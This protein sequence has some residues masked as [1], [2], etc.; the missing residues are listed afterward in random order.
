[1][2]ACRVHRMKE[3]EI[4]MCNVFFAIRNNENSQHPMLGRLMLVI[5]QPFDLHFQKIV[6]IAFVYRV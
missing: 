3:L 6:F 5:R 1:M 4:I 2:L